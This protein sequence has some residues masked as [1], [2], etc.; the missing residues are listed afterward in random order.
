MACAVMQHGVRYNHFGGVKHGWWRLTY[1]LRRCTL[2][3][4]DHTFQI[5]RA[6]HIVARVEPRMD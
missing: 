2:T 4:P 3:G 6:H 5:I 1:F